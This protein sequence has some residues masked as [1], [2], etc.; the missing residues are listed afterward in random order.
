[1]EPCVERAKPRSRRF[2]EPLQRSVQ[3]SA[4]VGQVLA[5][6]GQFL[7]RV[8]MQNACG[9]LGYAILASAQTIQNDGVHSLR[10]VVEPLLQPV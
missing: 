3:S 5:R 10:R 6:M 2:D 7:S 4:K 1:M 9:Q 8:V